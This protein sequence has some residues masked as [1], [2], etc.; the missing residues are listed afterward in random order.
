MILVTESDN[1]GYSVKG[2]VPQPPFVMQCN[3]FTI[4][5]VR[6][7]MAIRD[8]CWELCHPPVRR[9]FQT[10]VQRFTKKRELTM[11]TGR[12]LQYGE[13]FLKWRLHYIERVEKKKERKK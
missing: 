5:I 13:M 2:H 3:D 9:F 1:A 10:A 8:G 12:W 11:V 4:F 7:D 6:I